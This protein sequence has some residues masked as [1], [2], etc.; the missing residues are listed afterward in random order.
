MSD[1]GLKEM[2]RAGTTAQVGHL[3]QYTEHTKAHRSRQDKI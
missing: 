1:H 2:P 3:L